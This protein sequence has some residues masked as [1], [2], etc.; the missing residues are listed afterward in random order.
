MTESQRYGSTEL[1]H[2]VGRGL[3]SDDERF[4]LLLRILRGG[5]LTP[6]PGG[7]AGSSFL[8]TA[9][10]FRNETLYGIDCVCFCDIPL[11]DL[12]VHIQKYSRFGLSFNKSFLL[13]LGV[14]P[15]FYVGVDTP[16][17]TGLGKSSRSD[18]FQRVII[19][20]EQIEAELHDRMALV[21]EL[22]Q[23]YSNL[24]DVNHFLRAYVFGFSKPFDE[25]RRVTD[26]DNYYM[27]REW[28][29]HG[30]IRFALP[31][32]RRVFLPELFAERLRRDLPQYHGQLHFV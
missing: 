23:L 17:R 20:L 8:N 9:G 21:P 3:A 28:R 11:A 6:R 5:H 7:M 13:P 2:F 18:Q 16:L 1:S 10:T 25:S 14:N 12:H 32:V 30:D 26:P 4:D 27:E 24:T 15:V 19:Q 29:V 22:K 31:D